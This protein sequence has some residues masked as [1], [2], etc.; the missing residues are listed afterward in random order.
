MQKLLLH[1]GLIDHTLCQV[2]RI[3]P[4]NSLMTFSTTF[5]HLI[6]LVAEWQHEVHML[7]SQ[8]K[9]LHLFAPEFCMVLPLEGQVLAPHLKYST[10]QPEGSI[11][12][13]V[14]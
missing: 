3:G 7:K 2:L 11:R 13:K 9:Q 5:A 1:R 10:P 8:K 14:V 4:A 12:V 6:L